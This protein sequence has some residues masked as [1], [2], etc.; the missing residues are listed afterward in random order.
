[1]PR[2]ALLTCSIACTSPDSRLSCPQPPVMPCPPVRP[3]RKVPAGAAWS[4][5]PAFER[6]TAETGS[7]SPLCCSPNTTVLLPEHHCAASRT[8]L[9]CPGRLRAPSCR[10]RSSPDRPSRSECVER[11]RTTAGGLGRR[12][13][14]ALPREH[15][16]AV[17]P[18]GV[19]S[20]RLVWTT[21]WSSNSDPPAPYVAH[22]THLHFKCFSQSHC[23][24]CS[25]SRGRIGCTRKVV[26]HA[27]S[28]TRS[29][30]A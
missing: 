19:H 25:L 13:R 9:C 29:G 17:G 10:L 1:S 2:S 24:R 4:R 22:G 18:P 3:F 12:P 28:R 20:R 7:P 11:P 5:L 27:G 26:T 14:P 8:P 16:S 30:T 6:I 23:V 21:E 15:G